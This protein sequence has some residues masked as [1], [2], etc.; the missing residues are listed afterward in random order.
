MIAAS[1]PAALATVW[2]ILFS[3]MLEDLNSR[4]TAIEITAAGIEVANVR[5]DFETQVHVGRGEGDGDE[6]AEQYRAERQ[7]PPTML[8]RWTQH[9][10]RPHCTLPMSFL[11]G[12][13]KSRS[14]APRPT[15][16]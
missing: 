6:S 14:T 5:S 10:K 11:T 1:V 16:K 8:L 15:E 12:R 9:R 3:K 13:L 2:T 7:L 4:S